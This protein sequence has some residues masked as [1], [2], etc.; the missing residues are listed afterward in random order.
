[1]PSI[2]HKT[3]DLRCNPNARLKIEKHWRLLHG[4]FGG[5]RTAE[6]R[7]YDHEIAVLQKGV[8][9]GF[10]IVIVHPPRGPFVKQTAVKRSISTESRTT[11]TVVIPNCL[12]QTDRQVFLT[13]EMKSTTTVNMH[14]PAIATIF[15]S[16]GCDKYRTRGIC[17]FHTYRNMWSES[18]NTKTRK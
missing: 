12:G 4:K 3:A 10:H 11:E 15:M 2:H 14:I 1:M 6:D 7:R 8:W 9:Q 5:E 16:K 18:I 17:A 13:R